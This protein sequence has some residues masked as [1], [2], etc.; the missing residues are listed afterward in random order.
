MFKLRYLFILRLDYQTLFTKGK[1]IKFH[2]V[3]EESSVRHSIIKQVRNI[4]VKSLIYLNY[5]IGV[6]VNHEVK[7]EAEYFS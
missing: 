3:I 7:Y 2:R 1:I 6:Q 5:S 4:I